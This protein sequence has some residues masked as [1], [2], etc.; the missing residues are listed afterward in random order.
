MEF[1]LYLILTF[2]LTIVSA[3]S[4][5]NGLQ[6]FQALDW[7]NPDWEKAG[8]VLAWAVFAGVCIYLIAKL[9]MALLA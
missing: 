9:A 3:Y 7:R 6:A 1:V 8:W 4:L 5:A 2:T